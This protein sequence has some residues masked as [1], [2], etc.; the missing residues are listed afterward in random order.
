MCSN[1]EPIKHTQSNWV[2]NNLGCDLPESEWKEHVFKYYLAPFVFFEDGVTRCELGHFGLIPRWTDPEE[3]SAFAQK[4]HNARTETVEIR[5]S[6]RSPWKQRRFGL[7]LADNFYEPLY[8]ISGKRS[9]PTPIYRSDR[10]PTAIASIYESFTD[11]ATGEIIRSFSM[12]TVNADKHPLMSHFHKPNEEKRSVVVIED[13][14]LHNWLNATH[15]EARVLLKLS[16]NGYLDADLTE[17]NSNQLSI[18]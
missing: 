10:E 9:K 16:P 1:Y 6:Y 5:K 18:F 2:R 13:R 11:E 8:D 15:E 7:V 4:T 12:L 17:P 3:R 14:D